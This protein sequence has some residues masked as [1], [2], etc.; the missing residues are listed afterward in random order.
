MSPPASA[1]RS[2]TASEGVGMLP[3]RMES[4]N[5]RFD[6]GVCGFLWEGIVMV[7]GLTALESGFGLDVESLSI[8]PEVTFYSACR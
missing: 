4:F 3:S 7:S 2:S 6:R 5:Q 1:Q 8:Y